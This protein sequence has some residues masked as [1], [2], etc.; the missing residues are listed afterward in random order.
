MNKN[1]S[2]FNLNHV[3]KY[4]DTGWMKY[5][6]DYD[7]EGLQT[8]FDS[9]I[10][11]CRFWNSEPTEC[12]DQDSYDVILEA[13]F[14]SGRENEKTPLKEKCFYCKEENNKSDLEEIIKNEKGCKECIKELYGDSV[15]SDPSPFIWI[16]ENNN[17]I[18]PGAYSISDI[19]DMIIFLSAMMGEESQG[20]NK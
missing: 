20:V 5:G 18:D 6:V 3:K 8:Y 2:L 1:S 13:D 14:I 4:N 9:P 12:G 19:C 15:N 16:P 17:S 10:V 7:D 11:Y